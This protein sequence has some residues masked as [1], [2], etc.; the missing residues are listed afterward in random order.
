VVAYG[1]LNTAYYCCAFTF[2]WFYVAQVPAGLS[3]DQTLRKFAEVR[4]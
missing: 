1:V 2:F 4:E 3:Y